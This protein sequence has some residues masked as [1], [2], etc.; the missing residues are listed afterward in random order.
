M[1]SDRASGVL[2]LSSGLGLGFAAGW[3]ASRGVEKSLDDATQ[4]WERLKARA[5]QI[6]REAGLPTP[7]AGAPAP[8]KASP[9]SGVKSHRPSV[10][11]A[12]DAAD[13]LGASVSARP[14][15][16]DAGD[17]GL[18][19]SDS[20]SPSS[21]LAG[22]LAGYTLPGSSLGS[23]AASRAA[24]SGSGDKGEKLKMVRWRGRRGEARGRGQ[25]GSERRA[26]P[27]LPPRPRA[28]RR[29]GGRARPPCGLRRP[30]PAPRM[31]PRPPPSPRPC[32]PQ[33]VVV[34][35]DITSRW[36]AGKLSVMVSSCFLGLYKRCYKNRSLRAA[37]LAW[38]GQKGAKLV[39]RCPDEGGLTHI[40]EAARG[41]GVPAHC[42]L[43]M[44]PAAGPGEAPTRARAILA[45][46]PATQG[47][48]SALGCQ[49]LAA[50]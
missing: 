33:V 40:M 14:S 32:A 34:R 38:E 50:L 23:G 35:D 29:R 25:L 26:S 11:D 12:G 27:R 48:L 43:E 13:L 19:D 10:A 41:A 8:G 42:L 30:R 39:L 45:L 6:A 9:G 24:S 18:L 22:S 3:A 36:S 7:A 46:G 20:L 15:C 21:S 1:S 31:R 17:G 47:A 37:L 49:S 44:V 16:S 2:L 4:L 28:P 5:L